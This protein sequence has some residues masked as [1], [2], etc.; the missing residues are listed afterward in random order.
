MNHRITA[1]AVREALARFY[2]SNMAAGAG[3]LKFLERLW[4]ALMRTSNRARRKCPDSELRKLFLFE[5]ESL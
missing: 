4:Q 5:P 3:D 1:V 2:F